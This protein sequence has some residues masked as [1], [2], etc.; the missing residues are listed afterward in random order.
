MDKQSLG[1]FGVVFIEQICDTDLKSLKHLGN[2][3]VHLIALLTAVDTE[4]YTP[5]F[6]TKKRK[7][8][9][10]DTTDPTSSV[11]CETKNGRCRSVKNRSSVKT[12]L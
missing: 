10:P 1:N 6:F 5:R 3:R 7:Y 12:F 2:S 8:N 11:A 9:P 4:K